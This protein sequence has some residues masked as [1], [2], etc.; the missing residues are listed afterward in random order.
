MKKVDPTKLST[1]FQKAAYKWHEIMFPSNG[2]FTKKYVFKYLAMLQILGF[3]GIVTP[4]MEET[5]KEYTGGVLFGLGEGAMKWAYGYPI[6]ACMSFLFHSITGL[7][8]Y[9]TR[10]ALHSTWNI[11]VCLPFIYYAHLVSKGIPK[12]SMCSLNRFIIVLLGGILLIKKGMQKINT[13]K[14][15]PE[16]RGDEAK[17]DF[18][19]RRTTM[20][21]WKGPSSMSFVVPEEYKLLPYVM[22]RVDAEEILRMTDL[23]IRP[24]PRKF[25]LLP[26]NEDPASS[27]R[28]IY[29]VCGFDTLG[30]TVTGDVNFAYASFARASKRV[31]AHNCTCETETPCKL[32]SVWDQAFKFHKKAIQTYFVPD[33]IGTVEDYI[34][35]VKPKKR[36]I[37]TKNW[38]EKESYGI[39]LQNKKNEPLFPRELITDKGQLIRYVKSRMF[40]AGDVYKNVSIAH[41]SKA[42]EHWYRDRSGTPVTYES[43]LTISSYF[44]SGRN[45]TDLAN[46]FTECLEKTNNSHFCNMVLGDD[47]VLMFRLKGKLFIVSLDYS[48]FDMSQLKHARENDRKILKTAV[49][50]KE[51]DF[52]EAIDGYIDYIHYRTRTKNKDLKRILHELLRWLKWR[53]VSGETITCLGNSWNN[54]IVS[55]TLFDFIFTAQSAST[56]T[57]AKII[58]NFGFTCSMFLIYSDPF[59]V[60]FLQGWFWPDYKGGVSWAPKV[61]QVV[62]KAGKTLKNPI[63]LAKDVTGELH[64]WEDSLKIVSTVL[65]YYCGPKIPTIPIIYEYLLKMRSFGVN[66]VSAKVAA[67][68]FNECFRD[69]FHNYEIGE[70]SFNYQLCAQLVCDYYKLSP[71]D[72]S[73]AIVFINNNVRPDTLCGHW[74]IRRIAQVDSQ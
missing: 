41:I 35:G 58:E 63:T 55:W 22:P 21:I 3:Y 33:D 56:S 66:L 52:D 59:G 13:T 1:L 54:D 2:G 48:S 42:T 7:F 69:E 6:P 8:G 70:Q 57:L 15:T 28:P 37:Y 51:T 40:L 10:V 26:D 16:V 71:D 60:P 36:P 20:D 68:Y 45:P 4:V 17:E 46:I 61:S 50:K 62:K 64:S 44:C 30:Y 67:T 18:E 73:E 9:K 53:R 47:G 23:V 27:G 34:K 65:S 11:S 31:P 25:G 43:G 29:P 39:I 19:T 49:G 24:D 12:N 74:V 32:K 14:P 72:L 38:E 5:V